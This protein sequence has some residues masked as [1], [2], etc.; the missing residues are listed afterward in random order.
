MEEKSLV[1]YDFSYRRNSWRDI[2][3]YIISIYSYA[4]YKITTDKIFKICMEILNYFNYNYFEILKIAY[5]RHMKKQTLYMKIYNTIYFTLLVIYTAISYILTYYFGKEKSIIESLAS[6][7]LSAKTYITK[8][9]MHLEKSDHEIKHIINIPNTLI[10]LK[11]LIIEY[12]DISELPDELVNI[13]HLNMTGCQNLRILPK[14]YTKI[15]Y[16]FCE[17]SRI[18]E[19]PNTYTQ[20]VD[21]FCNGCN[22]LI[23]IPDTYENLDSI[24]MNET[25]IENISSNWKKLRRLDATNNNNIKYIPN[26]LTNL[27]TLYLKNCRNLE[28]IPN[29]LL[30]LKVLH[31]TNN[32]KIKIIPKELTNLEAL[33]IGNTNIEDIPCEFQYLE[34]LNICN[35]PIKNI[36]TYPILETLHINNMTN[37]EILPE[38]LYNL[39]VLNLSDNITLKYIPYNILNSNVTISSNTIGRLHGNNLP[40]DNLFTERTISNTKVQSLYIAAYNLFIKNMKQLESKT[41]NEKINHINIILSNNEKPLQCP[42]CK[43]YIDNENFLNKFRVHPKY[44]CV[45][46]CCC[47]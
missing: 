8:L 12:C 40:T 13:E 10:N 2:F 21:L 28:S 38:T 34:I 29:T 20:I 18:S 41:S 43:R 4:K 27:E 31:I 9:D 39:K 42:K 19:L 5:M 15:K 33:N 46:R 44:G 26:T 1:K 16:L 25:S 47:G 36:P 17:R 3:V 32:S 14:T 6:K 24:E 7:E 45:Y 22:N 30:K 11:S 23:S 35:T 37:I